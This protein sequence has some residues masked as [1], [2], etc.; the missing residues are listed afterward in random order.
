MKIGSNE[1][2]I[3]MMAVCSLALVLFYA[4]FY[5]PQAKRL[6]T[7]QKELKTIT[8][9]LKEREGEASILPSVKE[10]VSEL[11]EEFVSLQERVPEEENLPRVIQNLAKEA[12]RLGITIVA[13]APS[14]KSEI[15][16]KVKRFPIEIDL[17]SSYWLLAQYLKAIEDLPTTFTID[18]L[19]IERR[20]G[21]LPNLKV[22]LLVS[23]Y[24]LAKAGEA[25]KE[26]V[27]KVIK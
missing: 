20:E 18:D 9:Q 26:M 3:G 2:T 23:S 12:E 19:V 11:E 16:S 1:K 27:E 22:R 8:N 5:R 21:L 17:E 24:S 7:I 10:K 13:I 25:I 14:G 15:K 4:V 6:A